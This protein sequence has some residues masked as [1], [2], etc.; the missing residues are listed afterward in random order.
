M[1]IPLEQSYRNKYYSLL[2]NIFDSNF[3][4]EG[5]VVS[6]FEDNFSKF[7]GLPSVA[8]VNGGSAILS[9]YEYAGVKDK[10][11]IVPANT[12]WAT[13][14]AAKMAG[15]KVIYADC[16]KEDLCL[17]FKDL[18]KKVNKNTKAVAVVHIGG[19][20]AFEIEEIANFC[21]ERNIYL[22]EDCA[23]AHGAS[24]NGSAA[25]SWGLG[26]A[27]SF[28]ATK[29]MPLGEG[30]MI[31][32]NDQ[33][34]LE[35][36]R[37]YRNYGK[38][39]ENGKVTYK[40]TNGF[41]FRMNEIT[42][43]LGIVQLERLPDILSWKRNLAKKLDNIFEQRVRFPESMESGYYKYVVFDS[44]LS[45]ES[46]KVFSKS[47]FGPE[48][49]KINYNLP[50]SCWVAEHHRCVPIWYGWTHAHKSTQEIS[51]LLDNK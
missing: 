46:G 21:R 7:S 28:Y 17:S 29:T 3:W 10:E 15:A 4:S 41:N 34:Y 49:E 20:I 35:W 14:I 37:Y 51:D 38:H 12:F 11:V 32:S 26:G 40:I 48:I 8:V 43:A 13:S 45:E 30:G 18:K 39:V 19:H 22:I 24:F 16:N 2:D 47:D 44:E 42:A 23:Q 5:K 9:M 50:N 31:C 1:Q 27:Y 6:S 25:G 33:D 36:L